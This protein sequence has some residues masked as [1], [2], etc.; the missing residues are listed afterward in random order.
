M[1][2]RE[3]GVVAAEGSRSGLWR[4]PWRG[5]GGGRG[6][7]GVVAVVAEE[8]GKEGL[9]RWWWKGVRTGCG[10]GLGGVRVVAEGVVGVVAE[11]GSG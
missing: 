8:V 4:W 11:E 3:V 10:S 2:W 7:V 9:R 6:R 5:R 1:V